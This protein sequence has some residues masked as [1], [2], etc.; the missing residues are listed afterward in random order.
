MSVDTTSYA[1][2]PADPKELE[3]MTEGYYSIDM[4]IAV[5]DALSQPVRKIQNSEDYEE[6]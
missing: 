1:V 4:V 2:S 3:K 5:Q 6:V